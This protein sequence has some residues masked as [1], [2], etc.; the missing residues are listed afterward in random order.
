[1]QVQYEQSPPLM[2]EGDLLYMNVDVIH[3]QNARLN[4]KFIIIGFRRKKITSVFPPLS[5]VAVL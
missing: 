3:I 1:M 2:D 4:L 5:A